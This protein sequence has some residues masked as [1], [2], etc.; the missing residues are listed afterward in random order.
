MRGSRGGVNG[1]SVA[2]NS[3]SKQIGWI[4]CICLIPGIAFAALSTAERKSQFER[5]LGL[6]ITSTTPNV[7]TDERKRVIN[8][9]IEG[10]PNKA[11]AVQDVYRKYFSSVLHEDQDLVGDRTLEACQM[12][13][14]RPCALIAI[15]DE[16]ATEG[17][18][19]HRDMPR[20]RYAGEFDLSQIPIIRQDTRNRADLQRYF[21]AS[22]PKAIAIH[23]W[24]E[25]FI[26]S[27]VK[28][29]QQAVLDRC[30]SFGRDKQEGPCFL[31]AIN[32]K[33]VLPERMIRP[34]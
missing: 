32:T 27:G 4:V 14:A 18:L 28:D 30:N 24:G 15:N 23:P 25:L 29:A 13:F 16:V 20:L 8:A 9:Y 2:S 3:R 5:V 22:E 6:V 1:V 17:Q 12:R 7:P 31:Y 34:K 26:A 11:L 33:V 19:D 10:K 21:G